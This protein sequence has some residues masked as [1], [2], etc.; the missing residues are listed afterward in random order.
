MDRK[1]YI[2]LIEKYHDNT[3]MDTELKELSDWIK[4]DRQLQ[5]WWEQEFLKTETTMNPIQC[6]KLF[7]RIKGNIH[8]SRKKTVHFTPWLWAAVILL[9]I[10]TAFFTYYLMNS[11]KQ[12]PLTETPLIVRANKGEKATIELPDGTYVILNSASQLSYLNSFGQDTRK[13]KLSGEA[14]FK[15]AHDEKRAFIVEIGD[16]DIKVLGTSFNVSAYEDLEDIT[17]VLLDGKVN[18]TTGEKSYIMKPGDR[19]DYHKSTHRITTTEVYSTDYIEWAKGNLYFEK[20]SLEN[21][22]KMLSRIYNVEIRFDPQQFP[23]ERLTGTIPSGSI[24]NA[25]NILVLTYPLYYEMDGTVIVIKR[26]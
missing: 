22:L 6:D 19:I 10:F 11:P 25:L 16:L 15:V 21:I 12:L 26:R 1:Y 5:A 18:L 8:T 4:Q 24:Q 17:I 3:I 13:V 9:P 14:Y 20:E 2:E 7:V 23:N